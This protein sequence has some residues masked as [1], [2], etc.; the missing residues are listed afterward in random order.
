MYKQNMK[1]NLDL[2]FVA[3]ES[4]TL[5]SYHTLNNTTKK[6]TFHDMY[7]GTKFDFSCTFRVKDRAML[8]PSPERW[9]KCCKMPNFVFLYI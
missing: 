2:A 8:Y 5:T 6:V 3:F 4:L 7:N 1:F 9:R